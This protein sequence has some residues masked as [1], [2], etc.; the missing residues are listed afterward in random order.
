MNFVQRIWNWCRRFRYRCGYGVHSPSDFFLITSVI[1]EGLPYYAYK[2]LKETPLLKSLP[3]YREK[4]NRLL[5]RLVNFYHPTLLVEVG[6]G[7]GDSFRYMCAAR[8]SMK[9]VGLKGLDKE[10]TLCLLNKELLQ[11]KSLDFL[12]IGFTPYYMEAFEAACSYL[13]EG[14]CVVIGDIY[15]SEERKEWWRRLTEDERVRIS[16]DLYDVGILL[17]EGKR[18]KQNYKVNFF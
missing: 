3:H 11:E 12:H 7:N 14:S 1:Y 8:P 2:T 17:F 5:F 4:V 18:F 16:F 15:A 9:S 13:H 10:E 6:E